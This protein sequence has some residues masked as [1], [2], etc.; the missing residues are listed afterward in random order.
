MGSNANGLKAKFDSLLNVINIFDKPSCITIQETKLRTSGLNNIPGYQVFQ[1][2][3]TGFGGGLLTAA[4]DDLAPVLVTANDEVEL[5]V[6]QV[7]I[8]DK[9]IRIFNAY[10]PQ[11]NNFDESLNFWSSLEKE[12]I[13][14]KQ[15]NCYI[16]IQMDANAKLDSK[17]H[18]M[19]KNG[20]LLLNLVQRQNLVIFNQLPICK[21]EVTR[22]RITKYCEEKAT[23][24]Y[25]VGCD[26]LS[27]FI[28]NVVIDE[29]RLFTLTKYSTTKGIIKKCLS[30]HNIMFSSFNLSYD[31]QVKHTIRRE[32]FNLNNIEC[33]EA[34]KKIT[35]E[36][37]K[38]TDIFE[39]KEAFEQQALKFQRC[40][41]QTLQMCF[42]KIRVKQNFKKDKITILHNQKL[43]L[44]IFIN[45]SRCIKSIAAAKTK[46]VDVEKKLED[47]TATR[48]ALL[49]KDY[50]KSLVYNDKFSQTSMW[51]LRKKLHP[52]NPMDPPM[53]KKDKLG[54][55][56]TA[57][58]LLRC[59]YQ[60]T[61]KDRLRHR[62]M[63][64]DF[65]D[66]Y[67]L[68]MKLWSLRCET[69]RSKKSPA[70]PQKAL[71]NV[72]KNMKNNKSRDPHG[73]L[74]EIL[75][76]GVCG[77][78]LKLGILHLVNGVKENFHFPDYIQWANITS[79]YK[80][81]GSRL[82]LENERGIFILSVL[83]KIIDRILYNDMVKD[84]DTNMSDSNIGG[85]KNK[86]IKNHLFIIY[87]I[88]N[89]VVKGEAK[90]I[91][92]Q[93]YDIKKAFDALWLEE[94][95]N[96]LADTIP[97]D[98]QNDKLAL[99]YE[100]NRRNLVA[101]NT[102]VGQTERINI[103][104]IVCQ[105][106]T[107]GSLMC[108]NSIDKIGK[109]CH[110]TGEHLYIYKNRVRILP[111]GM[112]DD[113]LSVSECGHKA[114]A[115][116]TFITTQGEL[117][118]LSFHVPDIITKKSKCHKLHVGKKSFTCPELKV[119]GHTMESVFMDK[120]LGDILSSD[121]TNDATLR[122]RKGKAIGC[123][124]NIMSIL[125]TISFGHHYFSILITLRESM[126]INCILTNSEVWFGLKES[127]LKELEDIDR[128][129]LRKA[130][131]CPI[132]TPKEAYYLELGITNIICIVKQRRVNY[133]YYLLRTDKRSML[134][135]FF[136]AMLDNPT[137]DDWT[138]S[139]LQDL[140]DFEIKADFQALG[141]MAK[142]TFKNLVKSKGKEYTLD[143][144]NL[145]K[146]EHSKMD[147]LV[148]TDLKTQ[149]YLLSTDISTEQKRNIFLFRT[150]MADFSENFK[151]S[152]ID[153][154]CRMCYQFRDSQVHAINCF[155]TMKHV[156]TK[157]NINEVY[158]SNI[159]RETAII[160]T[161]I[162]KVRKNKLG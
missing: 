31:K 26:K 119:H 95:L 63:K 159:S 141:N 122:D 145:K 110:E 132:S 4:H 6:I 84:I 13:L 23:L 32:Q 51:K 36:T 69:L 93:I 79:I 129:L 53:A 80:K 102:P 20:R 138:E 47:I 58:A 124:N 72:L 81:S 153:E 78:D 87:G 158:T 136:Q 116:N 120:Y 134:H 106:G 42:K 126:F 60:E 105:G 39:N 74:N 149:D 151:N 9:Q 65:S 135:K 89:A 127:D 7:K 29:D 114:V 86:N 109:K 1:L 92:I 101:I 30:D 90:P 12:I 99:L 125:D 61:Y 157:G 64:S 147:N 160:I 98:K 55:L 50:I 43:K 121:G 66:V 91:D 155:E 40:V 104:H 10:G 28:E 82:S 117:K 46:L 37:T 111:L 41:K 35:E 19:S 18:K 73:L 59:L 96:D 2:N 137:K 107:W 148:Y 15:E 154:P 49:V 8:G 54:N 130:L 150:R 103:P 14:S 140:S 5:L 133:L 76:P 62:A 139:V 88:I 144:M 83:R 34:F 77:N 57:P 67:F 156:S 152:N 115:L 16:L 33:Q 128:T 162:A 68:K 108:S 146:F 94:S 85:R 38:F 56:V 97:K 113:L 24:D 70:W 161:H 142:S 118:K 112:V 44:N 25:I 27:T 123:M 131:K 100:A 48:N 52:P 17:L 3:R 21:G 143:Q 45:S 75:K 71:D 22:H 11:E